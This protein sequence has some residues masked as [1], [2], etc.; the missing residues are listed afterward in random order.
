MLQSSPLALARIGARLGLIVL[1]VA[2]LIGVAVPAHAVVS[3]TAFTV[4]SEAGDVV[5][6]GQSFTFTSN[7]ATITG[8]GDDTA[9]T[10]T[11]D[12][13]GTHSFSADLAAPTG[14]TLTAGTTYATT[15][16]GDASHASL[17]VSG[18]GNSCSSSTGSMTVHEITLDVSDALATLAV[19]YEQHCNGA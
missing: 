11:V 7:N 1:V 9:L 8:T 15:K 19:T 16:T 12:D 18:D 10:M 3:L 17:D 5:G 13:G 2:G 4:D 14:G 6:G